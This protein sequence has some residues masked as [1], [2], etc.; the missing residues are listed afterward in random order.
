MKIAYSP[1]IVDYKKRRKSMSVPDQSLSIQEIVKRFVRGIPVDV[2]QR[3]PVYSDQADYDLEKL[4]RMD[5]GEKAEYA[6]R[7]AEEADRLQTD[8]AEA[9][10]RATEAK[11]KAKRD[12]AEAAKT[13]NTGGAQPPA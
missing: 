6:Q 8:Y 2:V 13:A 10:A 1:P 5:F 4:A 11:Q 7:L 3:Q 12:A 9:Q